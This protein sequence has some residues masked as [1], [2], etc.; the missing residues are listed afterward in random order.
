[1]AT[2]VAWEPGTS[3]ITPFRAIVHSELWA[4]RVND[5][6][7]YPHLYTLLRDGDEIGD[8]DEWP[9]AWTR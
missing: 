4:V 9:S 5:F 6:P 2:R 7:D 3:A 1:M 8:F